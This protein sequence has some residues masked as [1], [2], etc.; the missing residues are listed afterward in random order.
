V[1][2]LFGSYFLKHSTPAA[3]CKPTLT[4][5]VTTDLSDETFVLCQHHIMKR[6]L[7]HEFCL[8]IV[9]V[10]I[11]IR[12]PLKAKYFLTSFYYYQLLKKDFP[13]CLIPCYCLANYCG[14]LTAGDFGDCRT[15]RLFVAI[16]LFL[17]HSHIFAV[18]F[19]NLAV[20]KQPAKWK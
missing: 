9:Y 6:Q 12:V 15:Y 1:W 2:L 14:S 16:W 17:L 8:H 5:Q 18:V 20:W 11:K 19:R 4:L 3:C 7:K 10:L 13:S